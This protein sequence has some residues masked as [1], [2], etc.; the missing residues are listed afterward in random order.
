MLIK[1][2]TIKYVNKDGSVYEEVSYTEGQGTLK[3]IVRLL[4]EAEP[5]H[6]GTVELTATLY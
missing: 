5:F 1:K 2:A 4:E 3:D 6:T